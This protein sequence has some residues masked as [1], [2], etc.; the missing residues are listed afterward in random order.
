MTGSGGD[1][2]IKTSLTLSGD[3]TLKTLGSNTLTIGDGVHYGTKGGGG[4]EKTINLGTHDLIIDASGGTII[5]TGNITGS[6]NI[7]KKGDGK[8]YFNTK[9][10]DYTGSTT[11][12]R[13]EFNVGAEGAEG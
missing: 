4:D 7:T 13:G 2:H 3:V 6:G 5:L 10:E 12:E 8:V 1:H 9:A 11:V